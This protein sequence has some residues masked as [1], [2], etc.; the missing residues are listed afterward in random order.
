MQWQ[1]GEVT[2]TKVFEK[3]LRWPFAALLPDVDDALVAEVGG[4]EPYL[5][6]DGTRMLL[7]IHALVV[8]SEG[9]RIIVDTCIGNA[10]PRTVR[11]FDRLDTPFLE[12]LTGAGFAPDTVDGVVCTHLHVDHIGWNTHL[13]DGEWVPTFTKARHYL[14]RTEWE[15]WR[16]DPETESVGDILADSVTP[17]FD[18]GLVDLVGPDL[19]LTSEVRLVPS[20]GHTPGHVSVEIH[21]G[22]EAAVI[23]G[24]MTHHPV[25]VARPELT[26]TADTDPARGIESRRECHSRWAEERALVI[27]THFAGPTA[28][29]LEPQP[30]GSRRFVGL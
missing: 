28:G 5:T 3:M 4:L 30:D 24:D 6:E 19:E 21:S 22:G 17:L 7:S 2:V 23:T 18:A 9:R 25:Q 20:P 11:G 14:N 16:D 27:G 13:V 15:H 10:K 26:S 1:V 12:D 29:H 8:E